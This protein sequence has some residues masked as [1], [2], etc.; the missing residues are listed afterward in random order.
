MTGWD[1]GL[2]PTDPV[3]RGEYLYGRGGADDGYSVFTSMLAIKNA[4]LQGAKLPRCA[5]V[6]ETEEE[7]GSADL[8]K[9]LDLAKEAIGRVDYCFCID[10]GA[11][12]YDKMWL[13]SSLRG[14]LCANVTVA[15]GK[16]GLHSGEVGGILPETFRVL[17]KLLDR[18]DDVD[19]GNVLVKELQ[20]EIPEWAV[21]ESKAMADLS[22]DTMHKKYD[23]LEGVQAMREDNLCEMYLN[24]TWRANVSVVGMS[25]LPAVEVAGNVLRASTTARVSI[26]LPPTCKPKLAFD[27]VVKALTTDVPY[28]CKVEVDGG[29]FGSG[30]CMKTLDSWHTEII[31]K[32]GADFFDGQD[33]GTYG[34]GGSIPFLSELD[35]MYPE[36]YIFALGL[37]G[38]KA[39]AHAANECINLTYAKKLTCAL[40]HLLVEVGSKQ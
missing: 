37:I 22:G 25:G 29:L 8:L 5:M 11:F 15:G 6:L 3:I 16:T 27:A 39:N 38:P 21:A 34:M 36:A 7:S 33:T 32:A 19:T 4:Q 12:N 13:T 9:L 35:S 17:R 26:R 14:V 2:G 28:N 30:W 23:R 10:S 20:V 31:R 24:N 40:S 18:V 1:E